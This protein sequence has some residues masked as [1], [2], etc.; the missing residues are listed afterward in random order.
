[1]KGWCMTASDL[2]PHEL[3]Q[4]DLID[5]YQCLRFQYDMG[6][7]EALESVPLVLAPAAKVRAF[8][9]LS[10][11]RQGIPSLTAALEQSPSW[12]PSAPSEVISSVS[13]PSLNTL[14]IQNIPTLEA[15]RAALNAVTSLSV[16]DTAM[17]MVFGEG[18]TEQPPVMVIGEAPGED[19]DRTGR[20]FV[21][22][23]GQL[24]NKM[25]KSIG[26][27]REQVYISNV[28]NW[29]PPGNRTPR[30]DEVAICL[31]YLMRHIELVQPQ[32]ILLTGA[33]AAQAV[34]ARSDSVS[35]LRG[36]WWDYHSSGLDKPIPA[37]VTYHPAYLLRSPHQKKES[38]RDLRLLKKKL[39]SI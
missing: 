34:L 15:L 22:A 23:A 8:S 19:E 11:P 27:A 12:S 38:W 31:P 30:P 28:L 10:P 25:L 24:L 1:M 21:G 18:L 26:F 13:K 33:L 5:A 9:S 17:N 37:L 4:F 6:I 16:K 36:Q 2:S 29:R 20:P 35:R 3:N 7:D 14:D 39:E 32:F